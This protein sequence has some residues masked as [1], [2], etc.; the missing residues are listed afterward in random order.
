MECTD[1]NLGYLNSHYFSLFDIYHIVQTVQPL[2]PA[3]ALL[4]HLHKLQENYEQP[5]DGEPNMVCIVAPGID[6]ET[7]QIPD[8]MKGRFT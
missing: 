4:A 2:L 3:S 1:K 6:L 8:S 7:V 5:S